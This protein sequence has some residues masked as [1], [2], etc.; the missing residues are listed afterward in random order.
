MRTRFLGKHK[1]FDA[2]PLEWAG[3]H[4]MR[5]DEDP[6]GDVIEIHNHLPSDLEEHEV[7]GREDI[8]PDRCNL[9]RRRGDEEEPDDEDGDVV[10]R[11]P[12]SYHV[13]TEG[14]EIVVYSC[15]P[16]HKTDRSDMNTD[17]RTRDGRPPQ[18]VAEL[19]AL[20]LRHYGRGWRRAMPVR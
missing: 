3:E 5:D 7:I 12:A 20:H 1:T 13:A 16:Q 17:R 2:P 4:R 8:V 15:A 14:D 9:A 11:Y 19:N 6:D 18:T 10:A